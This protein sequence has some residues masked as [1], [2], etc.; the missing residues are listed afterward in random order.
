MSTLENSLLLLQHIYSFTGKFINEGKYLELTREDS[1]I[2]VYVKALKN[3]FISAHMPYVPKI[4]S[5]D[6]AKKSEDFGL[7]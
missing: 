1:I 7:E 2:C 5:S 4:T 6:V 3:D